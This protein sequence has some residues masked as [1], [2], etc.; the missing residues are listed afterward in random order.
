M[1]RSRPCFRV[2]CGEGAREATV[3]MILKCHKLICEI[4]AKF[5]PVPLN[6]DHFAHSTN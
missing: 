1:Y 5:E 3:K 4:L 6:R 2:I